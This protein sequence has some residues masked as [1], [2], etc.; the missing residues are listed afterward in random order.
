MSEAD[1]FM[2][3]LRQPFSNENRFVPHRVPLCSSR[4]D[5]LDKLPMN[6]SQKNDGLG[7]TWPAQTEVSVVENCQ[8]AGSDRT[9]ATQVQV[10]SD[11]R[12][13]RKLEETAS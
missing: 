6:L 3:G 4:N 8:V 13:Y 7:G 11:R 1:R 5:P 9:G 10:R 12:K 2:V